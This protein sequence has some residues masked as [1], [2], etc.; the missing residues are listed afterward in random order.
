MPV[1]S[2]GS[3]FAVSGVHWIGEGQD[4]DRRGVDKHYRKFSLGG[5]EFCLGDFILISRQENICESSAREDCYVARI[6]DL[7][8]KELMYNRAEVQRFAQVR[9]YWQKQEVTGRLHR[10]LKGQKMDDNEVILD[11]SNSFE[12]DI[13]LETV[14]GKCQVLHVTDN[15]DLSPLVTKENN[16]NIQTFVARRAY[17]GKVFQPLSEIAVDEYTPATVRTP[18]NNKKHRDS[19]LKL[20]TPNGNSLLNNSNGRSEV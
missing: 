7:Y 13:D 14:V 9:W 12:R 2:S 1:T 15:S 3:L 19:Q 17:N 8:E 20:N 16:N 10:L 18:V 4:G 6:S 11:L 5:E